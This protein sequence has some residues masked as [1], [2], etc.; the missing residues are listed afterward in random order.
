MI[1]RVL[2]LLGERLGRKMIA[3]FLL[4]IVVVL[5]IFTVFSAVREGGRVKADLR[6][7]G[8][9]LVK[10]LSHG[11]VVGVFAEDEARLRAAAEDVLRLKNVLAVS[12]YNNDAK[13][14]YFE[15]ASRIYG[16]IAAAPAGADGGPSGGRSVVF[17]ETPDT[18]LISVPVAMQ[19]PGHA[20]ESLYFGDADPAGEGRVIGRV[21]IV[22]SKDAYYRK[23]G[24]VIAQHAA[25]MLI[26]IL[27]SGVI[28]HFAVKKVTRPLE[29]LTESVKALEQ[30]VSVAP[31]MI[32]TNDEVGNLAMAFNSMVAAR[33]R[34]EE[35]LRQSEHRFRLI[36][37]TISEVFWLAD[38]DMKNM[39]Y[40]SPE[41]KRAWGRSPES[42]YA[43]PGSFPEAFHPDDREGARMAVERAGPGQPFERE[44][45]IVRPD[46]SVRRIWE[47]GYPVR[48]ETGALT[49]HVGVA[50]DVTE[51][52][53]MEEQIKS[54][55]TELRT[56]ALELSSIETR[57]EERERHLIAT[58]L[59]DFV[60]QNLI[61]LNFKLGA[62]A[63]GLANH[64]DIGRLDEVRELIGQTIQYTRSLTVE[65]SPRILVELGLTAAIQALAE[66]YRTTYGIDVIVEDD[67]LRKEA[68]EDTRYLLFRSIRELLM[69]AVKHS[70]AARVLVSLAKQD[71]TFVISVK[72]DGVGFDPAWTSGKQD[73]FGLHS[74]R[75]RLKRLGGSCVIDSGTGLGATIVLTTPLKG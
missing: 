63:K 5:T 49:L 50:Q 58:D 44:Y 48:D 1:D 43:A 4:V 52:K 47:R 35:A 59:H 29:R 27:S 26:F 7:Q 13:L 51:R 24:S 31:V 18:F 53:S 32:E 40:V 72:D 60:G 17:T 42:L 25:I 62:L 73:G 38:A 61:V 23:I 41:Y 56:A 8:E 21:G 2:H 9:M 36:A 65:L 64:A 46:G 16:H 68:D 22:L 11:V 15:A 70:K 75:E 67:G 3:A 33:G 14:L 28:A 37:E 19:V 20:G 57:V 55:R 6:E 69:N 10:L 12:I 34:A 54:Y 39:L 66:G 71:D 30:G 45:R 74:I